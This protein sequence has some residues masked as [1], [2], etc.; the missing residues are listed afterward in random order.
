ML[1]SIKAR[2]YQWELNRLAVELDQA[3]TVRDT[4]KITAIRLDRIAVL[5][6]IA[7]L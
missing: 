2:L 1:K 7:R 4:Q 5:A 3:Y 6:D